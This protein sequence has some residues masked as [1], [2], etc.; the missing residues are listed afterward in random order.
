MCNN[1][2]NIKYLIY[3][4]N[5]ETKTKQ[6]PK[7]EAQL[8]YE[9]NRLILSRTK[10]GLKARYLAQKTPVIP[11]KKQIEQFI[12]LSLFIMNGGSEDYDYEY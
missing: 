11:S 4:Y 10:R 6:Q 9:K 3:I 1:H 8:S 7:N 12:N 2:L 5:M